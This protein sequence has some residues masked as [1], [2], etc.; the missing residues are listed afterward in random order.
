ME[1]LRGI[2]IDRG[3]TVVRCQRDRRCLQ[4]TVQLYKPRITVKHP[5]NIRRFEESSSE[6]VDDHR[7]R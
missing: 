3:V 7:K 5:F 6:S 2:G 4:R 1:A